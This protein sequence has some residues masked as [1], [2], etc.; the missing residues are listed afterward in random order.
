MVMVM[1]MSGLAGYARISHAQDKKSSPS[2]MATPTMAVSP[3][4]APAQ[5]PCRCP[6]TDAS[7]RGG[8]T[9]RLNIFDI[10]ATL[11]YAFIG[12][13]VAL[14]GYKAYDL[15]VPFD[16]RKELEIDQNTS[17]G[18]VVGS[19]IIGLSIIIA[20]AIMSP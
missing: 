4:A 7:S 3:Q 8:M 11:V 19:I 20:A 14:V 1:F 2:A 10:L 9:S 18:I 17:L 6:S 5:T 15:I 16:L 12:L 13:V